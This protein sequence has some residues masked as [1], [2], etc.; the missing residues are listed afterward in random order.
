MLF[1]SLPAAG[2]A[3]SLFSSLFELGFDYAANWGAGAWGG[4]GTILSGV[5]ENG[6]PI[7]S[8]YAEVYRQMAESL[9]GTSQIMT[10]SMNLRRNEDYL[11]YAYEDDAKAVVFLA[12]NDFTGSAHVDLESFGNIEYAWLERVSTT[13]NEIDGFVTVV[14]REMVSYS[15]TGFDIEFQKDRKSVV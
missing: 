11:T 8:P 9:V 12:A 7:Y 2:T 14:T 13:G 1:R 15:A 4:Y 6:D 3:L 5:D 10:P